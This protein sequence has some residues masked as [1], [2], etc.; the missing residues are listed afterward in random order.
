MAYATLD[1]MQDAFGTGELVQRT[2]LDETDA[3]TVNAAVLQRALD[4]ASAEIDGYL[5]RYT[6]P[7]E[8]VPPLLTTLCKAI[9]R[10]NLYFDA[11]GSADKPQWRRNYED[12]IMMLKGISAGDIELGNQTTAPHAAM[13][14]TQANRRVF[15]RDTLREM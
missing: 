13:V 4:D 5:G 3:T 9:A 15:T 6:L 8:T 12:A 1:Q 10:K 2:N 7:F 14:A 11:P